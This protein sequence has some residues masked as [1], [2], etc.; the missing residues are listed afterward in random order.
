[1]TSTWTKTMVRVPVATSVALLL[2]ASALL[3]CS[4]GP[5]DATPPP[6]SPVAPVTV[7]ADAA[8]TLDLGGGAH[9]IIPP[10]AMTAGARVSASYGTPPD[11]DWG[12]LSPTAHPVELIS[13]PP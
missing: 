9:L 12:A 13:D 4:A 10:G 3:A 6:P 5:K 8:V 11:D 7:P 2:T 1:M